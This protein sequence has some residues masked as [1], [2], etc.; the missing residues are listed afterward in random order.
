[1]TTADERLGS[2]LDH[3]LAS[4]DDDLAA[5]IRK[6][7]P[8]NAI[9]TPMSVGG[10]ALA[11]VAAASLRVLLASGCETR[12]AAPD[13]LV[14]DALVTYACEAIAQSD[15]DVAARAD[16]VL[17]IVTAVLSDPKFDPEAVA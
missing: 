17:H 12:A 8:P 6:A 5:R 7:L 11:D 15:G 1:M 4:V 9:E 10:E 2:W 16:A 13:L 3:R 14:I